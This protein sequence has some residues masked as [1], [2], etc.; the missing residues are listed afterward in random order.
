M[1]HLDYEWDIY[2]NYL[3]IDRELDLDRLG[4]KAGD[5]FKLE[6]Y[7]GQPMLKK[8]DPVEKFIRGYE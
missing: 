4:W 6:N 2:P 3:L 5:L 8:V 7:N 1:K